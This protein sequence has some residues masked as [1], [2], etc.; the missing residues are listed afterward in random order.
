MLS[1]MRRG[2]RIIIIQEFLFDDA[3]LGLLLM[4]S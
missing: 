1:P 2:I 4:F 3:D